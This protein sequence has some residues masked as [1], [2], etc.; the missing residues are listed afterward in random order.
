M[1]EFDSLPEPVIAGLV[2][3]FRNIYHNR[4]N[5]LDKS[6]VEKDYLLHGIALIGVRAVLGV[7]NVK[8]SPFNVQ[9]SVH[10][11]NL[12]HDEVTY[13]FNQYQQE[14]GQ[15]IDPEVIERIWYE[16]KGQP[17]LTNWFGELLTETYNQATNQPIT[18]A[19]F[20]GIYANALD[21]L[22][23]NNI[24]NI[25]SKAKQEPYKP[26]VLEMFQTSE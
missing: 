14:S 22:P 1:D 13:L 4:Q 19:H 2:G 16:F 25:I 20:K 18:M 3:F 5:Q 8:G 12:T 26:F 23:N 10:I 17:G 6:S 7:E 21:L 11:P 24:L 15:S 9:R